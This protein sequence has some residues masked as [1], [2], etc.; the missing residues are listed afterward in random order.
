[1]AGPS[2]LGGELI[3]SGFVALRDETEI[4]THMCYAEFQDIIEVVAAMEADVISL[5]T[6]RSQGTA[7]DITK[8]LYPNEI[9]PGV[10]DIQSRVFLQHEK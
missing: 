5:E 3:P 7:A 6:S 8:Y 1:M 4:H 10:Y 9:G 2:N